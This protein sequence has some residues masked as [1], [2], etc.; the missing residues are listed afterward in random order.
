MRRVFLL[1]GVVLA[2]SLAGSAQAVDLKVYGDLNNRFNLYT[3]QAAMYRASETVSSKTIHKDGIDESWGEIKYRLWVEASSNDGKVKG[4]YAIEL[5]ALRF[6]DGA[7]IGGSTRTGG[8]NFSGDGINIE[9]RWAYTDFQ[10]PGV[11]GKARFQIGLIP[12]T[13]NSFV[14]DE[15]AMGV[16]FKGAAGPTDLTLAW[17]RGTESFNASTDDDLFEDLDALLARVDFKPVKDSKVGLFAL[18]QTRNPGDNGKAAFTSASHYQVKRLPAADLDIYT[19]G[20]DGSFTFGPAFVN[21]DLVYQGGS[22][23]DN[24]AISRDISAYL[25]HADIGVNFGK[26]RLTYTIIYASGDDNAG[27]DEIKNF[28]STDVDRFDSIIFFEGG[29][30]DDNYFTEAPHILDKGLF[31]NKLALDFKASNKL[32][33]GAAVLYVQTAKDLPL[34]GGKQEKS[35]G[36]E[37][38]A[39]L[40]YLLFPDTELAINAG[41][42]VADDGMDF[43]EQTAFQDGKSD[44]DVFRSTARVRY[45]F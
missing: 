7:G 24:T 19:L 33:V 4:V 31:L 6:G 38:D 2:V 14:W 43:F 18:Y 1:L 12:F 32:S 22:L 35:L 11:A 26:A 36:T 28:M 27:D 23:D 34:A 40:S 13:V 10:L 45:K 37:I 41:Y 30:T 3:D 20:T 9:T 29:Y 15:T 8:G 44:A 25:A 21:W 16:Q 39:Y 42:L 5:G 17:V